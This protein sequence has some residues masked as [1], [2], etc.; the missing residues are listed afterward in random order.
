M[1]AAT[2]SGTASAC[3]NT[4]VQGPCSFVAGWLRKLAL[5]ERARTELNGMTD[6]ELKD[7]G[8]SR[9]EIGAVADGIYRR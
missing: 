6:V 4:R 2:L 7:I 1:A 3:D 9:G 5:A 8:L